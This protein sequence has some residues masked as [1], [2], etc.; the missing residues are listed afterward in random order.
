MSSPQLSSGE[1]QLEIA[2]ILEMDWKGGAVAD[3]SKAQRQGDKIQEAGWAK[4]FDNTRKI[5]CSENKIHDV[6]KVLTTMTQITHVARLFCH[7]S[8]LENENKDDCKKVQGSHTS[9]GLTKKLEKN[10]RD[11]MPYFCVLKK[12]KILEQNWLFGRAS[13][14]RGKA[15]HDE[16]F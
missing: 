13:T 10:S 2:S 16:D 12:S 11:M 5:E 15:Y 9:L 3:C 6:S 1:S 8:G 4:T 14:E 7:H